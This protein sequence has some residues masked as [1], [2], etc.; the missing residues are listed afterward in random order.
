M[1]N[2]RK[3]CI[4]CSED[5][6]TKLEIIAKEKKKTKSAVIKDLLYNEYRRDRKYDQMYWYLESLKHK[7][8]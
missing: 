7:N 1:K 2:N 4:R 5:F 3:L 8:D 6:L